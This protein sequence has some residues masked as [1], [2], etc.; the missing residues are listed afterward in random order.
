MSSVSSLSWNEIE[1]ID[2]CLAQSIKGNDTL[3]G[4]YMSEET[5][6]AEVAKDIEI[7][8]KALELSYARTV[9]CEGDYVKIGGAYKRIAYDMGKKDGKWCLQFS[10]S[11]CGGSIYLGKDGHGS[12]SGGLD[13]P[14]DVELVHS[15]EKKVGP[16]WTFHNGWSGAHRGVYFSAPFKVWEVKE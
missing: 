2:A 1:A 12:Y 13:S 14:V 15:D 3:L 4:Q 10:S 5:L 7:I 6:A 8:T 9:P 11:N 16:A